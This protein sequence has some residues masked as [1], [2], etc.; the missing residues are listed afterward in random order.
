MRK[1]ISAAL[2]AWLLTGTGLAFGQT[3]PPPEKTAPAVWRTYVQPAAGFAVSSPARLSSQVQ[4]HDMTVTIGKPIKLKYRLFSGTTPDPP[5]LPQADYKAGSIEMVG[6]TLPPSMS[7]EERDLF[8]DGIL[9]EFL[10]GM[11]QARANGLNGKPLA[12]GS[13]TLDGY[14]G[15]WM[16]AE[17]NWGGRYLVFNEIH[18]YLVENWVLILVV[19]CVKGGASDPSIPRFFDSLRR[20]TDAEKEKFGTTKT[21]V[22]IDIDAPEEESGPVPVKP[23]TEAPKFGS[24]FQ[25][26]RKTVCESFTARR[27]PR[28]F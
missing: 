9:G 28:G 16:Q 20:L 10:D 6:G 12:Q 5:A 24:T 21:N 17:S 15:R 26:N 4:H 25:Q 11:L 22:L 14:R 27:W 23:S 18:A 3:A 13:R 1:F 7:P 19:S 2:A 8:L